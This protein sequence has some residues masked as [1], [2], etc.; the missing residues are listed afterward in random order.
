[1]QL[2]DRVPTQ[3]LRFLVT[4]ILVQ[5]ESG[6]NLAPTLERATNTI[7]ER[8][9]ILGELRTKTA[10]ARLSS[11][12]LICLP[13][14]LGFGYRAISPEM[15]NMLLTD[16]LGRYMLTYAVVSS[17]AGALIIRMIAKQEV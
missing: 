16:P 13:I 14:V 15:F 8:V 12:I 6:G 7:R 10:N 4:A 2:I 17:I 9:R 3:D 1:M 5:K 11:T